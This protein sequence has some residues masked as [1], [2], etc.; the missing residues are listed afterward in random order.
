MK[1][2]YETYVRENLSIY[3]HIGIRLSRETMEFTPVNVS[4]IAA[5]PAVAVE[6][7]PRTADPVAVAA[8][9]GVVV[10]GCCI[11]CLS[12]IINLL[13]IIREARAHGPDV[14]SC[15]SQPVLSRA[16]FYLQTK[17]D[18]PLLLWWDWYPPISVQF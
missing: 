4:D 9:E 11:C 10:Q 1:P 2:S 8:C 15:Q 6:A 3:R 5:A 16:Y 18:S 12:S 13:K 7:D 14:P 17:C